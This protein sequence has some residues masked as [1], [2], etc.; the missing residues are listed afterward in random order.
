[1]LDIDMHSDEG[2]IVS[3]IIRLGEIDFIIWGDCE[4]IE[5]YDNK[6]GREV[7]EGTTEEMV[8]QL[9]RV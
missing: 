8:R 1:M 5:F 2:K 7:F 9:Q 3:T 6:E 4:R